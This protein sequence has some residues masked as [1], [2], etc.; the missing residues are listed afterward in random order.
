MKTPIEQL[1]KSIKL[2]ATEH[3]MVPAKDVFRIAE[4]LKSEEMEQLKTAFVNGVINSGDMTDDSFD[5]FI[6]DNYN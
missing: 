5:L 6:K 2:L 4:S 3:D 1:I